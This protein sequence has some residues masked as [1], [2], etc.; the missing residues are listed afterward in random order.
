MK[1]GIGEVLQRVSA[2]GTYKEKTAILRA[3]DS[4]ALQI[5]VRLAYDPSVEWDLEPGWRPDYKPS[6]FLDQQSAFYQSVRKIGKFLVDGHPS[7]TRERK[8]VLFEQLL[9]SLAPEDAEVLV[10]V[11]DKKMPWKGLGMAVFK[12]AFPHLF[13]ADAQP[14]AEEA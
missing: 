14:E 11:K 7:L 2:A 5:V 1:L 12:D 10:A 6:V 9:E 13:P 4:T 3:N 8:M